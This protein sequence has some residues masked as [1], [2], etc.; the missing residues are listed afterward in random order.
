MTRREKRRRFSQWLSD[1]FAPTPTCSTNRKILVEPLEHR[2]LLAADAFTALLGS[3]HNPENE[4]P[5]L[6]PET[7]L[8]GEGELVA[9]GEDAPDLV[10]FA[11]ALTDSGTRFFG[12]GWCPQCTAQKELFE[13]GGKYLPFIEVTNPDRTTNQTGISENITAFPTWEFPDSSRLTGFQS[14]ATLSARSGVPIPQSSAP[15][16][17]QLEDV[18]VEFGAPLHIPIDAY[19]PNGNPLTITVSSDNPSVISAEKLN[20]NRSLRVTTAGYGDMVFELFE[21]RAP[22][23]SG[24]VATLAQS[25]FYNG[26]SFHRILNNFVIQ[27]GDPTGTGSGGSTL[28]DFDDQYHVDLQHNRTGILSYAKTDDDTNDSQF[29]ITEGPQRHLDFQHSIFG[30]LVEGEN[31]REAISNTA[32]HPTTGVPANNIIMDSVTVFNDTENGV[33]VLKAGSSTGSADITVTVSDGQGNSTSQTFTATVVAPIA[34]GAPFLTPLTQQPQTSVNTP[35]QIPLTSQDAEND[36][37]RYSVTRIGAQNYGLTVDANTGVVTVTPPNGFTGELQFLATVEQTTTPTTTSR[38]DNQVISVQVVQGVPTAIDLDAASDSGTSSTDNLTNATSLTFTVSGTTSGALVELRSGSTVIGSATAS[39]DTTEIVVSDATALGQGEIQLTATQTTGGQ[40]S[41]ESPALTINLDRT[42]PIDLAA[43]IIPTNTIVSQGLSVNLN[44]GEEGQG[45]AYSLVTAPAGMTIGASNGQISWTPTSGQLGSQPITLALTDAA[46]NVTEQNFTINVIEEP[47]IRILLN[48][49]NSSGEPI[50][51]VGIG[52]TFTV[53]VTLEDLRAGSAGTGVFAAYVDL[54]FDSNIIEPVATTPITHVAPYVNDQSGSTATPGLIDELGAFSSSTARLGNDLRILAE[55]TFIAKATGNAGLR[56]E[57]ADDVGNDIL[58]YDGAGPVTESKSQ[59]GSSVFA[60]GANFELVDDAFNFDEDSSTQSLNVLSN[61]TITGSDT[62]TI[63]D[64]G[65]ASGGGTVTIA[66]DGKSLNYTPA[67]NF[68]G[69]EVFTYTARNQGG[70]ELTASVTIQVTDVNDPPVALNDTFSVFRNSTVN[71]LEVLANDTSGVDDPNAETLTITSVSTGSAGGTIAI[72]SSGLT[73]TYTPAS[74]FQGTES[75]T[76]TLSDGRGGTTTGSV[77]VSVDV[78]NPPPTPQ[79]DSF[80][81]EEDAAIATYDVLQN[82]TTNDP[83]ETLSISGVG[84][85]LQGSTFSVSQDGLT[86]RYQP[87]A[88]FSGT[89]IL[90][91]TLRDSGGAEANGLVTFT[92]NA[93]NDPPTAVDDTATAI[94]GDGSTTIDVLSNDT[95]VDANETL[96]I[97]AVTQPPS[98]SGTVTISSGGTSVIYTSPSSTFEGSFTFTYTI[99]DG[100]GLSDT[101][102]VTLDVRDFVPR[103]FTGHVAFAGTGSTAPLSGVRIN[104]VGTDVTGTAV[105]ETTIV[106]PDG[107]YSFPSMAPGDYTLSRVA[108]PFLNDAG[109]SVNFTSATT[110][111]NNVVNDLMVTGTL[112]PQFINIRDFLGSSVANSLTVAVGAD[113]VQSWTSSRGDWANLNSLSV[114]VDSTTDSLVLS[115]VDASSTNVSA[116]LPIGGTSSRVHQSGVSSNFRLLRVF[117]STSS[118]GLQASTAPAGEGESPAGASSLVGEGEAPAAAPLATPKIES[119]RQTED[120]L[121]RRGAGISPSQAIRQLL[122]SSTT[123]RHAEPVQEAVDAAMAS[124]LPALELQ[125]ASDLQNSLVDTAES[126]QELN[127]E[128]IAEL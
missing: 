31:N 63:S 50:T 19:D 25:G 81:L 10:A 43:G 27:G 6:T 52:E 1:L 60:V 35:V 37:V 7:G 94:A 3:A 121:D 90:T 16:F 122:G 22:I 67:A 49:V 59:L 42:A 108:L 101:A 127:D 78:Q 114:S 46:G 85:S 5:E 96:Q 106:A 83:N 92:V 103:D 119:V 45:L 75:F 61:D 66:G 107:T 84:T 15:S 2:Q 104:L 36:Q 33:I 123:V 97:T 113:G 86:V 8:T 23:P 71:V 68:N 82:D 64:V 100:N 91:Y 102:T 72:G 125:L 51:T 76:Y 126:S 48:P 44:H 89:E 13:D 20:G 21:Q 62:L 58:L 73:I 32:A 24:R 11:K 93:V 124:V 28:G 117:G 80:T 98:G 39:G 38:D 99:G 41:G 17:A 74:E 77:T 116:T 105:S 95:N 128:I 79:N 9:E 14:L 109:A 88:N 112:R 70:V 18:N 34:N 54:L 120:N 30:Q 118:S 87:A 56:L 53:Q 111:V 110:D 12:A 55:V 115:G 47:D 40:T 29:F 69:A 4:L 57:R 26:I 65:T